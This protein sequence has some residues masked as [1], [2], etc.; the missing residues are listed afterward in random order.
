MSILAILFRGLEFLFRWFSSGFI[1]HIC[2]SA[3]HCGRMDPSLRRS[4]EKFAEKTV[5]VNWSV[6]AKIGYS[7]GIPK[8]RYNL[9]EFKSVRWLAG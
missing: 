3:R 1:L 5:L 6:R 8:T 9:V 2:A 4:V 7:S